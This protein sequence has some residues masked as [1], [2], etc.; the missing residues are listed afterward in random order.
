MTH[1]EGGGELQTAKIL[2]K[3]YVT[4]YSSVRLGTVDKLKLTVQ[5]VSIRT[6]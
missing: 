3:N 2:L 5:V 6:R 1:A 4:Y